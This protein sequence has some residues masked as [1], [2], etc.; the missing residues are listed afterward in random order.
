[1]WLFFVIFL[2]GIPK[3]KI[4]EEFQREIQEE[5]YKDILIIALRKFLNSLPEVPSGVILEASWKNL[6]KSSRSHPWKNSWK[7]L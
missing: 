5:F 6:Q 7:H 1:M 3:K 2:G 4:L